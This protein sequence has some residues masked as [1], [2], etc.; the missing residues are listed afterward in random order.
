MC[1]TSIKLT[2]NTVLQGKFKTVTSLSNVKAKAQPHKMNEK[3]LSYELIVMVQ[4]LL[5]K[6]FYSYFD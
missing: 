1:Y 6:K 3:Q 2:K 4:R 5:E